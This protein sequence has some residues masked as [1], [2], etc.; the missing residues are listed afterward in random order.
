[1][2]STV[3][4]FIGFLVCPSI[5]LSGT[6]LAWNSSPSFASQFYSFLFKMLHVEDTAHVLSSLRI[7]KHSMIRYNRDRFVRLKIDH[8]Y[9]HI[10]VP[11][12]ACSNWN[13]RS[14]FTIGKWWL[15]PPARTNKCYFCP[16]FAL[17]LPLSHLFRISSSSL[18]FFSLIFS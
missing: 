11:L 8:F 5:D 12:W 2:V 3:S 16:L 4:K 13:T 6:P 14:R 15:Q 10:Y 17:L 1:M 18:I 9:L 7:K